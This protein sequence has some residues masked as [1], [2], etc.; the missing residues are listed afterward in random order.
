MIQINDVTKYYRDV[1]VIE[2][3][4][5]EVSDH[6]SLVV[7][8]PSGCGKTTLLRLIAGLEIPDEGEIYIN[9]SLVSCPGWVLPPHRRSIGFVFQ[10]SALWPHMTV[11]QNIRFGLHSGNDG[12][13][14]EMLT[15]TGLMELANRYPS[16]ISGG[17]ARRVALARALAPEPEY[18]L[19]D[20]PLTNLDPDLKQ[21][22]LT[23]IKE[24]VANTGG[25][26][27]YVTHDAGEANHISE[28]IIEI[29]IY[30]DE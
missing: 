13:V 9:G 28:R 20:E 2:H 26:L 29:K 23:L 8:G 27:I 5:L 15:R 21:E 22:M 25:S 6:T 7:L 16:Q 4:S 24:T 17:Q 1:K 18:L 30:R 14:Q 3:F 11:S 19:L 10:T 12:R